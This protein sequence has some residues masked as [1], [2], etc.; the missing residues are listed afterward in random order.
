MDRNKQLAFL[1]FAK[2]KNWDASLCLFNGEYVAI[3]NPVKIAKVYEGKSE[4]SINE[5]MENCKK[6]LTKGK[7]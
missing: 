1:D 6:E 5:A 4:L 3:L 2:S 7:S